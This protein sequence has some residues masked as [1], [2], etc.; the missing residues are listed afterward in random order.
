MLGAREAGVYET[1]TLAGRPWR[2]LPD[3]GVRFYA[4]PFPIQVDG[5]H[6]IFFED[7]DH[8]KQI[9]RISYVEIGPDGS[10][11]PVRALLKNHS[12]FPTRSP[13]RTVVRYGCLPESSA[14]R[15]LSL[16]RADP[17][18][19]RWIKEATVIADVHLS[20]ATLVSLTRSNCGC[21]PAN[22]RAPALTPIRYRCLPR[23]G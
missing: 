10:T 1:L 23:P 20:D 14:D 9:A 6:F 21:S 8:R 16:Y 12:I 11:S 13:L 5:R 7:F 18:P 2:V 4:D 22:E 19:L 15:T 3:P 17:F